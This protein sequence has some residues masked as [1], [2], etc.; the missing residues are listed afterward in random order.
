MPDAIAR[1]TTHNGRV[2][3]SDKTVFAGAHYNRHRGSA[4]RK[5]LS[6]KDL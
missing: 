4:F 3:S 1:D 2:T 6:G 5:Q